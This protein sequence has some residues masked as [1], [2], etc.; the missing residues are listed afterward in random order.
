MCCRWNNFHK[1]WWF[2]RISPIER[3]FRSAKTNVFTQ[4]LN[5]VCSGYKTTIS[6]VGGSLFQTGHRAGCSNYKQKYKLF[7]ESTDAKGRRGNITL[8]SAHWAHTLTMLNHKKT[9]KT[10]APSSIPP[11]KFGKRVESNAAKR[12][13]FDVFRLFPSQNGIANTFRKGKRRRT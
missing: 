11:F 9:P 12:V 3:L 1:R 10:G 2:A 5:F 7:P 13:G 8:C 6:V 4:S